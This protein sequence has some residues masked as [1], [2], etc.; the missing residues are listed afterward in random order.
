MDR[1]INVIRKI[2]TVLTD[3]IDAGL[4]VLEEKIYRNRYSRDRG[5][6]P[7]PIAEAVKDATKMI[8]E[9][10]KKK[11]NM[12][13]GIPIGLHD[14]DVMTGGFRKGEI[15]VIAGRP[16]MGKTAFAIT[17]TEHAGVKNKIPGAFFS[18]EMSKEQLT[19]RM[20]CSMAHVDTHKVRTGFLSQSDWPK[21]V[22]AAE[23]LSKAPVYIDDTQVLS[24][25]EI[26]KKVRN[27]KTKHDIQFIILDYL[28]CMAGLPLMWSNDQRI[29]V[30][31]SFSAKLARD[32]NIAVIVLSQMPRTAEERDDHRPRLS[33]LRE[34][35]DMVN[36]VD[37]V[38][39]L[40]REE[41]YDPT[42]NNRG[43]AEIIVAKQR[44][45]SVGCVWAQFI[46]QYTK[47]VDLSRFEESDETE[48]L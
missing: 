15:T 25:I 30:F 43:Q 14:L 7:V 9:L 32:L 37:N 40:Y 29:T 1:V 36:I 21:L 13:D 20:L 17:I 39:F 5:E 8:E 45:G 24:H 26:K 23:K 18:L 6:E 28:Q 41:Y 27:L 31:S 44:Q 4:E 2:F 48:E 11:E 34:Y 12:G 16:S 3:A 47:F 33:D 22:K 19:Q 35:G 38:M 42:E 10:Y 46:S